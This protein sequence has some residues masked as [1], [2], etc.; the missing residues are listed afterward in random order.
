MATR[1]T[2]A[3]KGAKVARKA[4][5][6]K[7]APTRADDLKAKKAAK[8]TASPTKAARKTA[9]TRSAEKN[10]ASGKTT[11]KKVAK[12]AAKKASPAK[13]TAKKAA[14]KAQPAKSTAKKASTSESSAASKRAGQSLS[15]AAAPGKDAVRKV[16]EKK[17]PATSNS[18]NTKAAQD[19]SET[20]AGV[21]RSTP[22]TEGSAQPRSDNTQDLS[23][24][25]SKTTP[26]KA[27]AAT[28]KLLAMKQE[29][30]SQP[31]PWQ[32]QANGQPDVPDPGFQSGEA[33]RNAL[34]L[35]AGEMR[36]KA[37][38]GS[39]GTRNRKNQGKRD[40]R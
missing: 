21:S 31:Q 6:K 26:R 13:T 9:T 2:A 22:K 36:M 3:K 18:S 16:A 7:A 29:R 1:K 35:H 37:I 39:V 38:G 27:L 14:K 33:Q 34:D 24:V 5:G 10:V 15:G 32:D 8:T 20:P 12:K 17:A 23:V 28:R 4:P 19:K 11:T 30:D 25:R 40:K